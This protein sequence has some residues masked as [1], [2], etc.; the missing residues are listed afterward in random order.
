MSEYNPESDSLY[1]TDQVTASKYGQLIS[2]Q[3]SVQEMKDETS[4]IS[5]KISIVSSDCLS[6]RDD[7]DQLGSAFLSND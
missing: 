7:F 4:D 6:V 5:T 1:Y 3:L 2:V